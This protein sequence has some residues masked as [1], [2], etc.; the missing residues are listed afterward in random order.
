MKT[1][2]IASAAALLTAP[3]FA[4]TEAL[5]FANR[6]FAQSEAP[7][8]SARTGTAGTAANAALV[9]KANA[10]FAKSEDPG[11]SSR[12]VI[13]SSSFDLAARAAAILDNGEKGDN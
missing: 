13:S 12:V 1:L 3:A 7:G 2:L 8:E 9:A 11:E 6:H 10:H 4:Q 5:D